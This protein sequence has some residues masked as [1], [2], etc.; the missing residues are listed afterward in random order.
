MNTKEFIIDN[1]SPSSL[2]EKIASRM[3]AKRIAFNITQRALASR[4]GVSLGSI[5]RF[6]T[7]HQISLQSLIQLSIV[8][9][10]SAEFQQLF[11]V[12]QYKSIA[13]VLKFREQRT[14]SR[15]R[16]A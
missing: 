10:A 4:S 3:K 1:F 8:L 11:P 9:D 12:D 2:A 6:E 5:K 7:K 13:E 16:D 14:R 15:A